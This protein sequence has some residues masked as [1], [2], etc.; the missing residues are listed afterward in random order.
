M[1]FGADANAYT[2]YD[3]TVYSIESSV[4][5]VDGKKVIPD[6]ALAILDD[7]SRAVLFM[8]KD[9]DEERAVIMEEYRARRGVQD[10]MFQQMLP[11]LFHDSKYKDR[12]PIGLVEIIEN[13][14]A[15]RMKSFYD[16]WYRPENMAIIIV[17]DFDGAEIER[18]LP[19]HFSIAARD[20]VFTRPVYDLP[21]PEKGRF[22]AKVI[23]DSEYGPASITVSIK[24]DRKER[25][26][27]L[28]SYRSELVDL[29]VSRMLNTRF[30]EL[31][32]DPDAPF[33]EAY[34]GTERHAASSRF[35]VFMA[36]AKE[37]QTK[38]A[39][40]SLL[41]RTEEALR[42]GFT[43]S[44]IG[45]AK[46]EL[47][48][49]LDQAV[50]E[51]DKQ[52][53]VD[54][55]DELLTYYLKDGYFPGIEWESDAIQTLLPGITAKDLQNAFNAMVSFDD[56]SIII[57]ANDNERA[58]LPDEAEIKA[59]VRE[60]KKARI[61]KP[62]G[63][64]QDGPLLATAPQPGAITETQYDAE[65]GTTR[66]Q[67]SNGAKVIVKPTQNKN[68]EIMLQ[69][70]ARGGFANVPESRIISAELATSLLEASGAGDYSASDLAG[71]L[72]GKNVTAGFATSAF[73]RS[74]SGHSSAKDLQTFFE[75]LHLLW[76]EPR[77]DERAVNAYL[78]RL[79]TNITQNR[80][81]PDVYFGNELAKA[82]SSGNPY[83]TPLEPED[84]EKLDMDDA[85]AF[86]RLC[87]NPADWTF[88]FTGNIDTDTFGTYLEQYLASIP[89]P[90]PAPAG[91]NRLDSFAGITV[92]RPS[93]AQKA[94]R[95]GK[96][97]RSTV[98]A[99]YYVP[100]TFSEREAVAAYIF[101]EYLDI[102]FNT[103]LREE[104]GGVYSVSAEANLSPLPQPGELSLDVY[105]YC[106]P[107]RADELVETVNAELAKIAAGDI[108]ADIFTKAKAAQ[109]NVWEDSMQDNRYIASRYANFA[110]IFDLPLAQL[111]RRGNTLTAITVAEIQA[112]ARKLSDAGA[113]VLVLNPE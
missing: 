58:S 97:N 87:R 6:K 56:T 59:I 108:S 40:R 41:T 3:E 82:L 111:Q 104:R 74:F 7:W 76:T 32:D 70:L 27:D 113:F 17:G 92:T 112:I 24:R 80:D 102:H 95:K 38:D 50:A 37:G 29:L 103:V 1:R 86:A 15:S 8:D 83:F 73:N 35:A 44:E 99:G 21:P 101:N 34:A 65:T 49:Y 94:I 60:V 9:A 93:P 77:F 10:R 46:A 66:F 18:N 52:E 98:F 19:A 61:A 39:L 96:E 84:L 42:Y 16:K 28:A 91:G 11:V 75:L 54:F 36:M 48:A 62:E 33:T 64:K 20:D 89:A 110:V 78:S 25:A 109:T 14:P 71:L 63:R 81:N 55:Q 88:V 12:L 53:S 45:R 107:A 13:A 68:D 4:E 30:A 85:Y 79:K 5:V 106:D 57:A 69:A 23:T 31:R 2:S 100:A 72:S 67:L 43:E 22:E 51:K 105:F 47:A 26:T 90:A